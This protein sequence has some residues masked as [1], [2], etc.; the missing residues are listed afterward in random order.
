MGMTIAK[1][2]RLEIRTTPDYDAAWKEVIEEHFDHRFNLP[3]TGR[4]G[5]SSVGR[6]R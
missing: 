6:H 1:K 3:F 5:K 2:N 4:P